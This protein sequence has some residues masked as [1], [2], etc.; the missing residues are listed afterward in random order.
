MEN[1]VSKIF[2][3]RAVIEAINSEKTISKVFL[4]TIL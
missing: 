1:E 3:L 2:G 4:G